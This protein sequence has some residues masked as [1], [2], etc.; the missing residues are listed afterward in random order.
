MYAVKLGTQLQIEIVESAQGQS[1]HDFCCT[2]IGCD[3]S[4][5]VNARGLKQPFVL[6]IDESGLL[7]ENPEI[8]FIASYLYGTHEH[9]RPIVGAALLMAR[10][11][12]DIRGLTNDEAWAIAGEMS[13]LAPRAFSKV[14]AAIAD[15]I[16]KAA[17]DGSSS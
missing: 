8:N 9:G 17:S 4:E 3:I 1:F 5:K 12:Y 16:E 15:K 6:M 11:H 10:H 13:K 14:R 2:Q 7:K